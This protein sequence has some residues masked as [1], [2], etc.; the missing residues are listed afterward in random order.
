VHLIYSAHQLH[1]PYC[2]IPLLP[3][4]CS[5]FGEHRPCCGGCCIANIQ[6]NV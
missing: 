1:K 6:H 3:G 5:V 2:G 4:D